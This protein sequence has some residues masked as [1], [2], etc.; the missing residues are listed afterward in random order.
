MGAWL[1][2]MG[3]FFGVPFVYGQMTARQEA[4]SK[5]QQTAY[6]EA[7]SIQTKL[8]MVKGYSDREHGALMLLKRISDAMPSD[9]D[10]DDVRLREFRYTRDD[11]V[12]LQVVA[13]SQNA[14]AYQRAL[15]ELEDAD[16]EK[17]FPGDV[18]MPGG[19]TKNQFKILAKLKEPD[20]EDAAPR[21]S[22]SKNKKGGR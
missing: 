1:V 19:M 2:V 22:S 10:T 7:K 20:E 11:S 21:R 5:R 13:D 15:H 17:L 4:A 8:N 18:E 16:G 6:S 14:L 3:V 12:S 9:S